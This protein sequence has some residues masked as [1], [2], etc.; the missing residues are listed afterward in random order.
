MMKQQ[1]ILLV[2]ATAL[3]TAAPAF[4]VDVIRADQLG[5]T[6]KQSIKEALV[7]RQVN[8]VNVGGH[9]F[10]IFPVSP[11]G[12]VNGPQGLAANGSIQH[13][14]NWGRNERIT[15]RITYRPGQPRPEILYSIDSGG[16]RP[17]S[18]Q[19]KGWERSLVEILNTISDV[20]YYGG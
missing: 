15:Y 2:A 7:G 16:F 20:L 6:L 3:W 10:H 4:A 14:V 5:L 1:R 17:P 12:S 19:T 9:I 13:R 11:S 18:L 8:N